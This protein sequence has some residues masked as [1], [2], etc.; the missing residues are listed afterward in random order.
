MAVIRTRGT[1]MVLASAT[2]DVIKSATPQQ[3]GLFRVKVW[4]QV[5]HN[6]T[7]FYEIPASNENTAAQQGINRFVF[8]MEDQATKGN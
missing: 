3:I 1:T 7:R 6:E 2:V 4:G 8:E 5:P